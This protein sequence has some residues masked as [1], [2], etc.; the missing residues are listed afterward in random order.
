MATNKITLKTLYDEYSQSYKPTELYEPMKR[1][2]EWLDNLYEKYANDYSKGLKGEFFLHML[3][4]A[5]NEI[6]ECN[7]F[8]ESVKPEILVYDVD[9]LRLFMQEYKGKPS[10]HTLLS[11]LLSR[12]DFD[13]TLNFR[14]NKGIIAIVSWSLH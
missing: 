13:I 1:Y 5:N 9:L 4:A 10:L 6:L 14:K 11:D 7:V 8:E 3:D 2:N 12:H